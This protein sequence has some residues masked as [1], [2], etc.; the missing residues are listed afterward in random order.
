MNQPPP[1]KKIP[2]QEGRPE[3][4][5]ASDKEALAKKVA[6]KKEREAAAA[7][8]AAAEEGK[9]QV[10]RK[11]KPKKDAGLDDLLNAGLSAT[12]KKGK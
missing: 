2:T 12:K 8:A 9:T 11:A 4:R 1:K 7:A 3:D 6:A 5:N 10:V